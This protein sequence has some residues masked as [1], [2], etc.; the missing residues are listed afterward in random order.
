MGG[1]L[2]CFTFFA[3]IK[4]TAPECNNEPYSTCILSF[5]TINFRLTASGSMEREFGEGRG[6]FIHISVM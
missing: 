6:E 4:I 3:A 2:S 1:K 5:C